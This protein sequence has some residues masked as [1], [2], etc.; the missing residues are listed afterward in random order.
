MNQ[1]E[2]NIKYVELGNGIIVYQRILSPTSLRY[3]VYEPAWDNGLFFSHK[4]E[5]AHPVYGRIGSI[6]LRSLP[7]DIDA[8]PPKS[9][10][11]YSAVIA[12]RDALQNER[13]RYIQQA[14]PTASMQEIRVC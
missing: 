12:W 2:E 1:T 7:G 4:G 13:I 10:E 6:T 8:L 11:R 3:G 5:F 14:F 9:M